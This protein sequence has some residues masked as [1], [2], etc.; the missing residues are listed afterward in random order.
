MKFSNLIL[1]FILTIFSYFPQ[2][3]KAQS[4]ATV[5]EVINFF[6]NQNILI[7]YREG[8]AVY[9]TYFFLEVHY[10][11]SGQYGLYGSS[12]KQTVMG[13]EQRN[14]W[15]EYGNWEVKEYQGSVGIYYNTTSGKENFAPVY[16]LANGDLFIGKGI[17]I[18]KQGMAIC[19]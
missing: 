1:V 9:G 3:L 4:N 8:E 5:T 12:V 14:S 15:R 16:R 18:V 17:S 11:P 6:N 13:L 19:N 2:N 10:C 7:T